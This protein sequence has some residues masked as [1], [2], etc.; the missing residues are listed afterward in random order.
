M[1]PF[2]MLILINEYNCV[3]DYKVKYAVKRRR[4]S[5]EGEQLANI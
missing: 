5:N 1:K 3:Q 4:L 2:L